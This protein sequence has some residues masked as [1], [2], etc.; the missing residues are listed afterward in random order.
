MMMIVATY[1]RTTTC[2]NDA[3]SLSHTLT[4]THTRTHIH[5]HTHM[6]TTHHVLVRCSYI[7]MHA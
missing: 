7:E 6:R 3:E 5:A 4:R 2:V 1:S